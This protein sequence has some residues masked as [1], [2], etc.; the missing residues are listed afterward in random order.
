MKEKIFGDAFDE[1]PRRLLTFMSSFLFT[2][3]ILYDRLRGKKFLK[4]LC[5]GGKMSSIGLYRRNVVTLN[6]T[7]WWFLCLMFFQV[8]SLLIADIGIDF[9]SA[10]QIFWIWNVTST[11][12]YECFHLVIPIFLE[13]PNQGC[14]TKREFY[15]RKNVPEPKLPILFNCPLK[16]N[17]FSRVIHVAEQ[18]NENCWHSQAAKQYEKL[19]ESWEEDDPDMIYIDV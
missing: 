1:K 17:T 18:E 8:L 16:T 2:F 19:Y 15:V 4:E 11:I 6:G 7:F 14:F 13:I 3:R 12:G 9:F 10:K 5:P